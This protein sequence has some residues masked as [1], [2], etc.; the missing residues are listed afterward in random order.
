MILPVTTLLRVSTMITATG[1]LGISWF[2]VFLMQESKHLQALYAGLESGNPLSADVDATHVMT[3]T[4][5]QK[6]VHT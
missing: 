6:A 4:V 1:S 2:G 3:V 5:S